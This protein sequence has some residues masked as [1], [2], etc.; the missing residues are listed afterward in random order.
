MRYLAAVLLAASLLAANGASGFT[1]SDGTTANCMAH[2]RAVPEIYVNGMSSSMPEDV[3]L[4]FVLALVGNRGNAK[5][6]SGHGYSCHACVLRPESRGH[7]RLNS[8]DMRDVPLIDPRFLS[9]EA[10]MEGMVAGIRMIRR[11]Y[12]QDALMHALWVAWPVCPVHRLGVHARDHEEAAV[13]WCSGD[14]G[15]AVAA[16]GAWPKGR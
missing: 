14:G 10:D 8:A 6:R 5:K 11:I 16:I 4:A 1:F 12:A 9:A 13:W 3:Q 2:G 7:V 15:H